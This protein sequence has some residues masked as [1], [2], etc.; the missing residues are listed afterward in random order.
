MPEKHVIVILTYDGETEDSKRKIVTEAENIEGKLRGK[1][2]D[3]TLKR[4]QREFNAWMR[5]GPTSKG[6][7]KI[8]IVAHGNQEQCGHYNAVGLA[9]YIYRFIKGKR[10]LRAITIHSCKSASVHPRTNAIFV[11][12][13]AS[14]L[15]T[16]LKSDFSHYIVV[17][18]SDGESYTDSTGRNWVLNDGVEI[19]EY[20]TRERELVFLDNNTKPRN[21]ARPRYAITNQNEEGGGYRGVDP[22]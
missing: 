9:D 8:H 14:K 19:P 15:L 17:R 21:T 2:Y 12:Q 6:L 18:G 3:V 13:F 22:V 1:G 10:D 11:E 5:D 16:H 7:N 4:T 20:R